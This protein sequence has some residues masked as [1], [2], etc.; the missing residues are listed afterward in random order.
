MKSAGVAEVSKFLNIGYTRLYDFA[1]LN[2]SI[3]GY[4]IT[5]SQVKKRKLKYYC[6]NCHDHVWQK[7]VIIKDEKRGDLKVCSDTCKHQLEQ[8][9]ENMNRGI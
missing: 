6:Q 9:I 3:N 4:L 8:K 1:N 5:Y 2:R 7:P